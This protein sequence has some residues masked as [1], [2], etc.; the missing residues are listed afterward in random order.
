MRVRLPHPGA[1]AMHK[2]FISERRREKGKQ[3]RDIEMAIRILEAI[4]MTE[5]EME[6]NPIWKSF[7]KKERN[8]ILEVLK[9]MDRE[10]LIALATVTP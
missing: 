4:Q 2:L 5:K 8:K 7:T 3:S 6:L 1:F 10:D 9:A